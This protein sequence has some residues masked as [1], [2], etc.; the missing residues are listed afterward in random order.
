MVAFPGSFSYFDLLNLDLR[1]FYLW[2]WRAVKRI[3]SNRLHDLKTARL[4][5][6]M[7]GKEWAEEVNSIVDQMNELERDPQPEQKKGKRAPGWDFFEQNPI[8]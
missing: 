8:G 2:A 1:D 6:E 3:L 5:N 4:G 7:S